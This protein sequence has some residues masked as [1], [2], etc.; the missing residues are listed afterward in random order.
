MKKRKQIYSTNWRWMISANVVSLIKTNTLYVHYFSTSST[1]QR[2]KG[3]ARAFWCW[4][5]EKKFWNKELAAKPQNVSFWTRELCYAWNGNEIK[6]NRNNTREANE[7][8]RAKEKDQER[9]WDEAQMSV[10]KGEKLGT[11]MEHIKLLTR[12]IR[13]S[14]KLYLMRLMMLPILVVA[15]ANKWIE[16]YR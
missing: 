11:K 14:H 3:L 15:M 10:G 13:T 2:C 4:M 9:D 5:N 6:Q 1:E 12:N 7:L 8:S 16:K